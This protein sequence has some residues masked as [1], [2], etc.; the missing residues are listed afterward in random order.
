MSSC[1]AQHLIF[2]LIFYLFIFGLKPALVYK[3]NGRFEVDQG[4]LC[5]LPLTFLLELPF[6]PLLF[7]YE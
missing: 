4:D 7:G 5:A 1:L 6:E 3:F 2:F